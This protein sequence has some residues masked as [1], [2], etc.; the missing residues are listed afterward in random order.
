MAKK[1]VIKG[2]MSQRGREKGG[3]GPAK[4]A[5]TVPLLSRI[6]LFAAP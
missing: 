4:A 6:R 2:F 5:V 1:D 3:E